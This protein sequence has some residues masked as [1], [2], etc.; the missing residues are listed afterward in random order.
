[1]K[2]TPHAFGS[3]EVKQDSPVLHMF[4]TRLQKM[5]TDLEWLNEQEEL[6]KARVIEGDIRDAATL[7]HL[8]EPADLA[9]TS[10]PYLN[11]LDYTMQTRLELFFLRWSVS[12]SRL[13]IN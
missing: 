13:R 9:V 1:M 6:G 10:P 5:I 3:R 8:H 4:E 12:L 2:L 11:N 7:A